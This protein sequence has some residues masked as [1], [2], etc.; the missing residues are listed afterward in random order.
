MVEPF[1]LHSKCDQ[2]EQDSGTPECDG[3]FACEYEFGFNPLFGLC[4][5]EAYEGTSRAGGEEGE[6][7]S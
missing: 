6:L 1:L 5:K 4:R 7:W 2:E 3:D